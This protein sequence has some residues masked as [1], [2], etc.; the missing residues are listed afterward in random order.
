ME[1][2][3]TRDLVIKALNMAVERRRP[4]RALLLLFESRL[5]VCQPGL[6]APVI[7][8]RND[9]FDEPERRLFG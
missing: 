3:L 2:R 1:E 9:L 8:L 7:A 5:P 4:R 6:S